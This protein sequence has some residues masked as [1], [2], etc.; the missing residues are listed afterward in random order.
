[1]SARP[2]IVYAEEHLRCELMSAFGGGQQATLPWV[3][4]GASACAFDRPALTVFRA[5]LTFENVQQLLSQVPPS[6][7]SYQQPC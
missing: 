1:M 2:Q 3:E 7:R 5:A 4:F 6:L